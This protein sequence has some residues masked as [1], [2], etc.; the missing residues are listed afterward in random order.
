M[1]LRVQEEVVFAVLEVDVSFRVVFASVPGAFV[2]ELRQT[3]LLT[4]GIFGG[5]F[6][7]KKHIS[8]I[9]VQHTLQ[10]FLTLQTVGS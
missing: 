9:L 3:V 10:I 8:T 2:M 7:T 4:K 5:T 6:I 1:L